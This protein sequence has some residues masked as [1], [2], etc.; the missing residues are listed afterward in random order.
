MKKIKKCIALCTVCAMMLTSTSA[1]AQTFS[2][3][4][5]GHKNDVFEF[6]IVVSFIHWDKDGQFANFYCDKKTHSATAR[7]RT[8]KNLVKHDTKAT[9]SAKK[10]AKAKTPLYKDV[11]EWNSYYSHK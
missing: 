2:G 10:W 5:L 4:S 8:T 7:V 3:S 6:G 11:R 1:F 9:A